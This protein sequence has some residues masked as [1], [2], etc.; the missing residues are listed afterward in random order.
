MSSRNSRKRRKRQK[1]LLRLLVILAVTVLALVGILVGVRVRAAKKTAQEAAVSAQEAAEASRIASEEAEAEASSKAAAAEESAQAEKEATQ[2]LLEKQSREANKENAEV[3]KGIASLGVANVGAYIQSH[4]VTPSENP[5][6]SH[7]VCIDA[8]H[9][10][11]VLTDTEPNGPGSSEMKQKV[12]SGTYGE[13]SGLWEYQLNLTVALKVQAILESRG[14]TV[15]MTRTTDDVAMSNIDRAEFANNSGAEIMVRIHA[16]SVDNTDVKG[17]LCFCPDN[18]N[19]Y[20]SADLIASSRKLSQAI[21]DSFCTAT[22]AENRGVDET[23]TLTGL[24]WTKIPCTYVEMGFMS[25]TEEDLLMATEDY[26][27][28][29]AEGIANGIDAYFAG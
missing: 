2:K 4:A 8:G 22:G 9:E 15:V 21:I 25:N 24:N 26:Q 5:A 1:R 29:M 17:A 16:N 28:K 23:N 11:G 27:N 12:S 14:Y 7:V 19:P 13:A 20:L 10:H 3:I 6:S 18:D